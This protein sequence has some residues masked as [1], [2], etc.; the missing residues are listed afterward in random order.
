MKNWR[1][2]M[3]VSAEEQMRDVVTAQ[4]RAPCRLAKIEG[5]AVVPVSELIPGISAENQAAAVARLAIDSAMTK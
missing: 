2:G 3:Y 1:E 4:G 5:D